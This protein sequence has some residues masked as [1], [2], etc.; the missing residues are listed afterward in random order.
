[1]SLDHLTIQNST[2]GHENVLVNQCQSITALSHHWV[3]L[4][5]S[6]CRHEA[7]KSCEQHVQAWLSL[8]QALNIYASLAFYL[9]LSEPNNSDLCFCK[10]S[11]F[12]SFVWWTLVTCEVCCKLSP[13]EILFVL[14]KTFLLWCC[15]L[16]QSIQSV[17]RALTHSERRVAQ[18]PAHT[19]TCG[20]E[21]Q[22]WLYQHILLTVQ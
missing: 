19:L 10:L 9:S 13:T 12:S 3:M 15:S 4:N 1:M 16:F 8:S 17:D 18:C 21:G 22:L 7:L 11:I 5:I 14:F 20:Q 6:V 2:Q